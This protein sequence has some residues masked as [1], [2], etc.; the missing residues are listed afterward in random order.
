MI[1]LSTT[2]ELEQ[3]GQILVKQLK[4]RYNDINSLKRFVLGI[5]RSKMKLFDL[6]ESA[7]SE[8]VNTDLKTDDSSVFD[9]GKFGTGMK[10]ERK[11]K[12]GFDDFKF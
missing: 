3:M 4:N 11:E 5:D 12:S 10:A 2:E 8:L 6:D 1:A 9:K 7:Q